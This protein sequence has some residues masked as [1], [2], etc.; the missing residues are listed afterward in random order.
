MVLM[1]LG[2]EPPRNLLLSTRERVLLT[3]PRDAGCPGW[4]V[5]LV[6]SEARGIEA[7]PD[8]KIVPSD[9]RLLG[10]SYGLQI[11]ASDFVICESFLKEIGV[12]V[13]E[14]E[15]A[16]VF[17]LSLQQELSGKGES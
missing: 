4:R 13:S 7:I 8:I 9:V 16:S 11:W 1:V 3:Q 6:W 17:K 2:G 15:A 14:G 5:G 12:A 10:S